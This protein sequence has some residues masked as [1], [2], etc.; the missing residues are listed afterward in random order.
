M[1]THAVG[2]GAEAGMRRFPRAEGGSVAIES[3]LAIVALLFAFAALMQ[4]VSMGSAADRMDR[5]ARAAA[6]AVA[7]DATADP[8]D[9]MRH[10]LSLD[11]P[12]PCAS[13]MKIVV[14]H[15]VS[16]REL[17]DPL[18]AAA[19]AGTGDLVLVRLEWS[20]DLSPFEG[21][22]DDPYRNPNDD[23]FSALASSVSVGVARRE[24]A[25]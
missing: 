12:T 16:P 25:R 2:E 7:L 3:A 14:D 21:H 18:D 23:W 11:A 15:D 6:Q 13:H 4:I 8:C 19:P 24:A 1:F 20:H 17:P 10:E 22:A 5:A 9:A